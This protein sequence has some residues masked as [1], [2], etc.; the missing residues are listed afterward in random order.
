[1][2]DITFKILNRYIEKLDEIIVALQA[3]LRVSRAL[4]RFYRDELLQDRKLRSRE[5]PQLAWLNARRIREDVADFDDKM[6]WVCASTQEML[7]R[8]MLVKQRGVRREDTVFS[9]FPFPI[10][11]LFPHSKPAP[12]F[13][14]WPI[15]AEAF[16][17]LLY[18]VFS[19]LPIDQVATTSVAQP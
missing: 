4:L 9:A 11:F 16:F 2:H 14:R 8:A 3:N 10:S 5:R 17:P 6:R 12:S 13:P 7:R 19:S 15:C 18:E 1:V